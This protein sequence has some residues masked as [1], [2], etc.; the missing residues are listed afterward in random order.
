MIG[1][2]IGFALS[3]GYEMIRPTFKK[4]GQAYQQASVLRAR[5]K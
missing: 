2:Y 5:E 3:W 1:F 4:L